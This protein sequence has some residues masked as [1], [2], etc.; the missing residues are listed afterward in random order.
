MLHERFG[1][2]TC[3]QLRDYGAHMLDFGTRLSPSTELRN[4]EEGSEVADRLAA[5]H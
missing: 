5:E 2:A 4:R 1:F 3:G